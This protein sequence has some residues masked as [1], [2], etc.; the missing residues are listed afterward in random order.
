MWPNS[1]SRYVTCTP[2]CRRRPSAANS[3]LGGAVVQQRASCARLLGARH[4]HSSSPRPLSQNARQAPTR[5]SLSPYLL[6]VQV[7]LVD[8]LCPDDAVMAPRHQVHR[9]WCQQVVVVCIRVGGWCGWW[10]HALALHLAAAAMRVT[11]LHACA[12]AGFPHTLQCWQQATQCCRRHSPAGHTA[13]QAT[14]SP[15]GTPPPHLRCWAGHPCRSAAGWPPYCHSH[16]AGSGGRATTGRSAPR[17]GATAPAC[18]HGCSI[19]LQR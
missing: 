16:T 8:V 1:Y 14:H 4:V 17:S 7:M 12:S 19:Q 3:L 11:G 5:P 13:L 18:S 10:R 15:T 9:D 2:A 6:H